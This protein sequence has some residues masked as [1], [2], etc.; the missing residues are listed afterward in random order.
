[1]TCVPIDLIY[2]GDEFAAREV[3]AR[4]MGSRLDST[5]WRQKA[6]AMCRAVSGSAALTTGISQD[7]E[8]EFQ[9]QT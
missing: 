2:Q 5:T 8:E 3:Q 9:T 1:M 6:I 7:L 4:G